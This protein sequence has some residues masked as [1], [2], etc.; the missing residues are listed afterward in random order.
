MIILAR[1]KNKSTQVKSQL[2]QATLR[3]GAGGFELEYLSGQQIMA[4]VAR[5][6]LD[7]R[8]DFRTRGDGNCFPRAIKQQ[9]NRP[10]VGIDIPSHGELRRLVCNFMTNSQEQIVQDMKE[11]WEMNDMGQGESWSDF[12]ERMGK[13]TVW[14]EG[15]FIRGT[16]L[17]LQKDILIISDKA[18]LDEPITI[19]ISGNRKGKENRCPG[20]PL[21]LGYHTNVH[22][23]SLLPQSRNIVLPPS[24]KPCSMEDLTQT[25]KKVM[26]ALKEKA[27]EMEEF[28]RKNTGEKSSAESTQQTDLGDS[29]DEVE[30]EEKKTFFGSRSGKAVV[31]A[32]EERDGRI[33]Y[34]CLICDSAPKQVI[35]HVKKAHWVELGDG[36]QD[37]EQALAKFATRMRVKK[38]RKRQRVEDLNGVQQREREAKAKRRKEQPEKV[39]KGEKEAKAKRRK[40]QPEKVKKADREANSR[41]RKAYPE[42]EKERVR[43]ALAKRRKEQPD[44]VKTAERE[45][46][47]RK[48]KSY[49]EEEKERVRDALAKRRKGNLKKVRK[50]ERDGKAKSRSDGVKKYRG[51]TKLGPVFP[52]ASCHTMK[53]RHQV[54]ILT[55]EQAAKIDQK[56]K[57]NH[58][59]LQ[60]IC[61]NNRS[62]FVKIEKPQ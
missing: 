21:L 2:E 47:S 58:E 27:R 46:N 52:C 4:G 41:K 43:D 1:D 17:F 6:G 37:L 53:F 51:E 56:A 38:T 40:E 25:L 39:K 28:Q 9:C 42:E 45:A 8:M 61:M 57:E 34:K 5:A 32:K 11:R 14:A 10:D 20:A 49:P 44:K 19:T 36:L 16:A 26:G 7:L 15:P 30:E 22:Y 13:D 54:V 3:G 59:A 60:V 33:E 24:F 62:S 31:E 35:A 29:E 23:Q 48:R 50:E 18:T 12:W 55:K